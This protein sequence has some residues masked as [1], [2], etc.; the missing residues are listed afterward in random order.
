MRALSEALPGRQLQV[1]PGQTHNVKAQALAPALA[2]FFGLPPNAAGD[3]P[4]WH[5]GG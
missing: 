3:R 1:V 5:D 2:E 4:C